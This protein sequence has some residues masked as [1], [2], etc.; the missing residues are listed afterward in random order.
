MYFACPQAFYTDPVTV[1]YLTNEQFEKGL[2]AL[3]D[4]ACNNRE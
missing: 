4:K 1:D 3:I 2:Q